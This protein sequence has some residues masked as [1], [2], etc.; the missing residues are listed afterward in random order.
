MTMV[1]RFL[2]ALILLALTANSACPQFLTPGVM[3]TQGQILLPPAAW[4]G[5]DCS[6]P[7]S[8]GTC[9]PPA[10]STALQGSGVVLQPAAVWTEPPHM[11]IVPGCD[12]YC[13]GKN[14]TVGVAAANADRAWIDHV[15][16]YLE[17][18][19]VTVNAP[20][21][22]PKT[23]LY[24]WWVL[25]QSSS[26]D[27]DAYVVADVY[28]TNGYVRRLPPLHVVLDT[29]ATITR[30][31]ATVGGS[32]CSNSTTSGNTHW[33]NLYY[34]MSHAAN[35]AL[36]TVPAGT[37]LLEDASPPTNIYP[38]TSGYN[39]CRMITVT[40]ATPGSPYTIARTNGQQNNNQWQQGA[41]AIMF[42]TAAIDNSTIHYIEAPLRDMAV[43]FRNAQFTVPAG[44][45][46]GG[47]NLLS[48][49]CTASSA[50]PCLYGAS[51]GV[52]G[53][54]NDFIIDSN[55]AFSFVIDSPLVS[56]MV[57]GSNFSLV[58]DANL[59]IA[60]FAVRYEANPATG[61]KPYAAILG[62]K[63]SQTDTLQDRISGDLPGNL[64]I[65]ALNYCALQQTGAP[66]SMVSGGTTQPLELIVEL[67]I[68]PTSWTA[69]FSGSTM[70]VT[71]PPP[72][73]APIVP[74]H[75]YFSDGLGNS[76][77][78]TQMDNP[79]G[80][81]QQVFALNSA[82]A[83]AASA[84]VTSAGF[85][86]N[87]G[88]YIGNGYFQT[89]NYQFA[90]FGV[91]SNLVGGAVM[92]LWIAGNNETGSNW[93]GVDAGTGSYPCNGVTLVRAGHP[94]L[95]LT[96]GSPGSG[97]TNP[98]G[99]YAYDPASWA[100]TCSQVFCANI[101]NPALGYL[102]AYEA[103]SASFGV[104]NANNQA[105]CARQSPSPCYPEVGD[106][107]ILY[108]IGHPDH[109]FFV[110]QNP[111]TENYQEI[112]IQQTMLRA[113][114]TQLFN[115]GSSTAFPNVTTVSQSGATVT[116]DQYPLSGTPTNSGSTTY[117]SAIPLTGAP[118]ASTWTPSVTAQSRGAS[119][120]QN[121]D[122]AFTLIS[123]SEYSITG[124]A[125]STAPDLTINLAPGA[126]IW[127]NSLT[128]PSPS[129]ANCVW[130][131]DSVLG[132]LA[133]TGHPLCGGE[134]LVVPSGS[135]AFSKITV[136]AHFVGNV[137]SALAGLELPLAN[138]AQTV[139]GGNATVTTVDP[140]QYATLAA[141]SDNIYV[142]P[143]FTYGDDI[144]WVSCSGPPTAETV[145]GLVNPFTFTVSHSGTCPTG[146]AYAQTKPPTQIA[147]I[148]DIL[149]SDAAQVQ[150]PEPSGQIEFITGLTVAETTYYG[151]NFNVN[152]GT[153]HAFDG[154]ALFDSIFNNDAFSSL[155][156]ALS[157]DSGSNNIFP[158]S[159]N[160]IVDNT[161]QFNLL[162]TGCP[163]SSADPPY[164]YTT[165]GKPVWADS[166]L[167]NSFNVGTVSSPGT[168]APN[169]GAGST[170]YPTTGTVNALTLTQTGVQGNAHIANSAPFI[171][172]DFWGN[173]IG[174]GTGI[175]SPLIG[176]A[177]P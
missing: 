6:L 58:R 92:P 50:Y 5:T 123:G 16:F 113:G 53:G 161:A 62:S 177:Q 105:S 142:T 21:K 72:A 60:Q 98:P 175:P 114:D 90:V 133:A 33:C 40:S 32:G 143:G 107:V 165:T 64:T 131:I 132:P 18:T 51:D 169:Q 25:I 167:N 95:I 42:D 111:N 158:A 112:V 20:S 36:I 30:P 106:P 136:A 7:T 76:D 8:S 148:D 43:G 171:P 26:A 19:T 140:Y 151:S 124:T 119:I 24:D 125:G 116:A 155:D 11:W 38:G 139:S 57:Q 117:Q 91:G 77:Y 10:V 45:G 55:N 49:N 46:P 59:N 31:T 35:G 163:Y 172:F 67:A 12:G 102:S 56:S 54:S 1:T 100:G 78:I 156:Y 153:T 66:T 71:S 81:G 75:M 129:G 120:P 170:N 145:I 9:A 164:A 150:G 162:C 138:V 99:G 96:A 47:P 141:A 101:V 152:S 23:G 93:V 146:S 52:S 80:S 13:T 109:G 137:T 159:A 118:F 14:Y 87:G 44:Q 39:P 63:Y 126:R 176:A 28:P 86:V 34:A 15:V 115:I 168:Y 70:T 157:S 41:C 69:N 94:F 110:A 88:E 68:T 84:T 108:D 104:L 89:N 154:S 83:G 61:P 130:Q 37:T 149:A 121:G 166:T 85:D 74:Y 82:W 17:G 134:T 79:N 173:A 48:S 160:M 73:S 122:I 174:P 22:D 127:P 144:S 97:V 4:N 65:S 147:Y 3:T 29:N 135:V 128:A 27:G 2:A 103:G